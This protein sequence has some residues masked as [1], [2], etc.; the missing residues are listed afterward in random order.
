MA[1]SARGA[2]IAGFPRPPFFEVYLQRK[3]VPGAVNFCMAENRLAK[4]VVEAKLQAVGHRT[5]R[6]GGLG[7]ADYNGEPVLRHALAGMFGRYFARGRGAVSPD[8]IKVVNGCSTALWQLALALCDPGDVM[9]V[10]APLYYSFP[11]DLGIV[12]DNVFA[13]C[14]GPA[15]DG[16]T[17]LAALQ[18]AHAKHTAAGTRVRAAVFANPSNPTGDVMSRAE[19]EAIVAWA[20]DVGVHVVVDEI[21]AFSVFR[22]QGEGFVSALGL[23]AALPE[24]VHV[25]WGLSKDF[26]GA[27]LRTGALVSTNRPLH[28]AVAKL[29]IFFQVPTALQH[30]LAAMLSDHAWL[31][32]TYLPT[33]RRELLAACEIVE[34]HLTHAGIPFHPPA[35]ALFVWCDLRPY[36][37]ARGGELALVTHL[38]EQGVLIVPGSAAGVE[39]W[40]RLCFAA[41]TPEEVD[42]GMARLVRALGAAPAKL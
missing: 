34:R 22:G 32:A 13:M 41:L 18:A 30:Q 14:G 16:A 40:A 19:L 23:G 15:A 20:G 39:G 8:D 10:P 21:Y 1:I 9:L 33:L 42:A 5:D 4:D 17:T 3:D 11:R 31:D 25:V 28:A 24:H 26:C 12:T 37:A 2:R 27:G 7:Y 6:H 38:A 36:C 29:G 35:A